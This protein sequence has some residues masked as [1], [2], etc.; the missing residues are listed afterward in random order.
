MNKRKGT[1]HKNEE[2]GKERGRLIQKRNGVKRIK[3]D[4]KNIAAW[5]ESPNKKF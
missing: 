1:K 3:I 5:S 4:T 2:R